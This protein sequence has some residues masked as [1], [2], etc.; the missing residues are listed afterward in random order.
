[1]FW[2][3]AKIESVSPLSIAQVK[4][5]V[6]PVADTVT[7]ESPLEALSAKSA[8]VSVTVTASL[9]TAT[10]NTVLAVLESALVANIVTVHDCAAS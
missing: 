10:V 4:L 2:L 8:D 3:I 5:P 9:V 7:T 1:M 6:S